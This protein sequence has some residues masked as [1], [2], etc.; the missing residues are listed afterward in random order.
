MDFFGGWG[1]DIN[2]WSEK[3]VPKPNTYM[4]QYSLRVILDRHARVS[5]LIDHDA[6]KWKDGLISKISLEDEAK[7]IKSIPLSPVFG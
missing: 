5:E 4:V 2:I 7:L 3:W 1:K 6:R